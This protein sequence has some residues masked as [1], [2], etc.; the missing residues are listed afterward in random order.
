VRLNETHASSLA[1][2]P[3]FE[4][5]LARAVRSRLKPEGGW[6]LIELL[7]VIIIA[8][9]LSGAMFGV[10]ASVSG[11]FASQGVRI[12]NQDDARSA[13]GQVTRYLRMAASSSDNQTSQSNSIASASSQAV[14]FYCDLDGDA[15]T[16]K[17]RYYLDGTTL[18]MQSVNPTWALTPTPHWVYGAYTTNGLVIQDAVRNGT[19]PVFR[20]WR[21][22]TTTGI[23]EE[24]APTTEALRQAIVTISISLTVNEAPKV[25]K[26]NVV[27]STDVQLRQRYDWGLQ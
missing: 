10:F 23:L 6:T 3:T 14:E 27:L 11:V 16:E 1:V 8:G 4:S 7:V 26:G 24:F 21:Y 19:G 9:V 12:Q 18:K 5:R 20:Y 2:L 15:I 13:L 25:A 17:A 22:N